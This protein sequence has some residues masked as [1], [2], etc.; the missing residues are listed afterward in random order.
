MRIGKKLQESEIKFKLDGYGR[1]IEEIDSDGTI[2]SSIEWK[3]DLPYI[4]NYNGKTYKYR[5]NASGDVVAIIDPNG[6]EVNSYSYDVFGKIID[7]YESIPNSI[8]YAHE[9]LDSE[10]GMYYLRGRY[11]DPSIRRFTTP[12]PA[13]DGINP[14]AYCWNN[15]FMNIDPSGYAKYVK[16]SPFKLDVYCSGNDLEDLEDYFRG[17]ADGF[18]KVVAGGV[19]LAT[20]GL[21]RF[22]GLAIGTACDYLFDYASSDWHRANF[23]KEVRRSGGGVKA[24]FIFDMSGDVCSIVLSRCNAADVEAYESGIKIPN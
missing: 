7:Q 5:C 24:T 13:E 19:G 2:I 6:V 23:C 9:Y 11:Y 22:L 15:P 10:T 3:D 20:G 21:N 14:Y 18:K 17:S 12:D 4:Y 8:K 16:P 1:V